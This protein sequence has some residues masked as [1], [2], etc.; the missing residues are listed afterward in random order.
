[1]TNQPARSFRAL[2]IFVTISL[3][4]A[5]LHGLIFYMHSIEAISWNPPKDA[6]NIFRSFGPTIAA[7]IAATYLGGKRALVQRKR[8]I[9]HWNIAGWL[10]AIAILGPMILMGTVLGIVYLFHPSVF[11]LGDTGPLKLIAFFFV[12]P[13]LDGPLGEEIGW[14]GYFLPALLE[15]YGPIL[16]SVV[17]GIVWFLWH[18]PLYH[19]DGRDMSAEFLVKY[20]VF[21]TALSVLHTWL[22]QRSG[23]SAFL[24]IVF[25]NSTNYVVLFA[26][27]LLPGL[28]TIQLDNNLYF[29]SMIVIGVI[30]AFF[31]LPEREKEFVRVE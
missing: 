3:G 26:I 13:F 7:V 30:G 1:M 5:V 17:V 12:T 31:L 18:L 29:F 4:L 27:L 21:T 25:H 23:R 15:R 11:V 6:L 2:I 14:R 22:F 9:F 20:L 24:A 19:A 10:Y 8:S 16:S 28:E